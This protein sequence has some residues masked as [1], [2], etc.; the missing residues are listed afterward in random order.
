MGTTDEVLQ[1]STSMNHGFVIQRKREQ[2]TTMGVT[3][4]I[5]KSTQDR[6]Q[7]AYQNKTIWSHKG[8]RGDTVGTYVGEP[9]AL[10]VSRDN[11]QFEE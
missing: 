2:R 10:I 5:V 3:R 8:N 7:I 11:Y 1:W 4:P 9:N 6:T